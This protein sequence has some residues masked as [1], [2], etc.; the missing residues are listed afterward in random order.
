MQISGL[1]DASVWDTG[2]CGL[3]RTSTF[4]QDILAL[5]PAS[6]L[7][8]DNKGIRFQSYWSLN[9]SYELRLSSDMEYTEAFSEIFINAVGCRLRSAFPV[10]STL[11][12]GIDSS[13][14][15]C[16]ARDLLLRAGK[17]HLHTSP[18]S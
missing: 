17:D 5:S 1:M 15:S 11:S 12:G 9:P 13:S 14:I 6:S 4:Y 18:S 7:T 16:T 3:D 10:G 2:C 8:L